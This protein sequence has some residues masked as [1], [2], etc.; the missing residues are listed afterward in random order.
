MSL[1]QKKN[2]MLRN[3]FCHIP[4]FDLRKERELWKKGIYN[5]NQLADYCKHQHIKQII[6]KSE[7]SI[8]NN[9]P[10]F[11]AA[12]IPTKEHW[13]LFKDFRHTLA[14][15]DIETTGMSYT[16]D[17]ITTIAL[18]N[19]EEIKCFVKG[20]N[21]SEFLIEI[22]KYKI[23]VTYNGKRFDVPFINNYF[24]IKLTHV[25]IDLM[26]ILWSLGYKGGLKA[27][28][29]KLGISRNELGGIDGMFAVYLW[30]EY[31]RHKNKKALETLLAYNIQDVL[32]LEKLMVITYNLKI[33]DTPFT[34]LHRIDEPLEQKNPFRPDK[35][36]IEKIIKRY[37]SWGRGYN[38]G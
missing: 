20:Q 26:Y 36:T 29:Y 6:H 34:A 32:N 3:T 24:G 31:V 22:E 19:G 10:Y 9:E 33:K 38:Y 18:Y 21:L 14:Y 30:D 1:Y 16:S 7:I 17:H 25:H 11:F 23:I 27:C 13:R 35:K 12:K 2:N 37:N 4:D 5:W 28:E 15:L 8:H